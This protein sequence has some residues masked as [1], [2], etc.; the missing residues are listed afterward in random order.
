MAMAKRGASI[1]CSIHTHVNWIELVIFMILENQTIWIS[2]LLMTKNQISLY[3]ELFPKICTIQGHL[4]LWTWQTKCDLNSY[5]WNGIKYQSKNLQAECMCKKS[6]C[7]F[8]LRSKEGN[9]TEL[10]MLNKFLKIT[11]LLKMHKMKFKFLANFILRLHVNFDIEWMKL[12]RVDQS[13]I[14]MLIT[15][16]SL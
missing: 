4:E 2:K 13:E 5:D 11:R 3:T 9:Y 16:K 14:R 8:W 12:V 1:Y 10:E 6:H 7:K 15:P